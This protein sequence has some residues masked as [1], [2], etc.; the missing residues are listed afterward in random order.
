MRRVFVVV[1]V[2]A[3]AIVGMSGTAQAAER[4]SSCAQLLKDYPRGV[5]QSSSAATAAVDNGRQKPSVRPGLYAANGGRLDVDDDGVMC[6]QAA[7]A[8]QFTAAQKNFLRYAHE[9]SPALK[10][11]S[12]A[13][14]VEFGRATC[15]YLDRGGNFDALAE[16]MYNDG[17]SIEEI[18]GVVVS[19]VRYLCPGHTQFLVNWIQAGKPLPAPKS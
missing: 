4:Y 1:V 6:E 3:V 14:L 2:V 19:S 9:L 10:Q 5:A 8:S 18:G 11:F 13:G 12:D 15:R 16:S 7:D 17:A